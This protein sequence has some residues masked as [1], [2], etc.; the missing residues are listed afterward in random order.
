MIQGEDCASSPPRAIGHWADWRSKNC[1]LQRAN[2][3]ISL[4]YIGQAKLGAKHIK[5]SPRPRVHTHRTIQHNNGHQKQ[6]N[7]STT[8]CIITP[9]L[10][11]VVVPEHITYPDKRKKSPETKTQ[12]LTHQYNPIYQSTR[13]C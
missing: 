1:I 6:Y 9:P 13:E 7:N 8:P 12:L 2:V 4:P 5:K 10:Q 11:R 3:I